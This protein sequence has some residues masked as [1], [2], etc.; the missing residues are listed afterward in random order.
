MR[1]SLPAAISGRFARASFTVYILL[2]IFSAVR[3]FFHQIVVFPSA[4]A[5]SYVFFLPVTAAY[6]TLLMVIY[7][8]MIKDESFVYEDVIINEHGPMGSVVAPKMTCIIEGI[9]YR[10]QRYP[11]GGVPP[12]CACNKSILAQDLFLA[13]EHQKEFG[14]K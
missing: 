2:A 7:S 11:L 3:L 4:V 6:F 10:C 12:M 5:V 14:E 8:S 1:N 13:L 9:R